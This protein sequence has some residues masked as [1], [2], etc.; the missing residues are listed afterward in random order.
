MRTMTSAEAQNHFGELLDTAQ[1]EPVTITRRGRPVAFMVS[2]QD[3]EELMAIRKQRSQ[4]VANFEAY[5][6][7]TDAK[8]SADNALLTDD[9]VTRWVHELR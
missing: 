1:R 6:A 4:A 3:M 7:D 9:E 2:K 5:F 8:L